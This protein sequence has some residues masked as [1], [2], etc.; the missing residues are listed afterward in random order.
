ML[1]WYVLPF[2]ACIYFGHLTDTLSLRADVPTAKFGDALRQQVEER[3]NFFE[4]GA[5]PSKNADAIRKV[6][7][8]LALDDD[9][10]EVDAADV[11]E[12]VLPLIE[13]EPS[14]KD[15]KRK[16]RSDDMD[17]DE[18]DGE[19]VKKVKLSKEEKGGVAGKRPEGAGAVTPKVREEKK[20]VNK[21]KEV[22]KRNLAKKKELEA[23]KE[24][25][26]EMA[27]A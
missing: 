26:T 18:D 13:A 19:P 8:Q 21:S 27:D 16:R 25:D 9:D 15:K 4:T 20:K 10:E 14:K 2:P 6:L 3:L 24:K 11:A 22:A 12:P 23:A 5:P 7:D 17:V 1:L